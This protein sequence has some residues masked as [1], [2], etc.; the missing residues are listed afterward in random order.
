MSR[1]YTGKRFASFLV[2]TVLLTVG[3][4]WGQAANYVVFA[5]TLGLAYA[6]YLGGQSA[7]DWQKAKNGNN[8]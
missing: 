4:F 3:L 1:P 7:T 5:Q 8:A 6:V 2:V